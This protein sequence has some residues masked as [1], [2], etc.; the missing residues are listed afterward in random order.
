MSSMVIFIK[1]LN[2]LRRVN[3]HGDKL[4]RISNIKNN[5][6]ELKKTITCIKNTLERITSELSDREE[7]INKLK[8][9]LVEI[10][11]DEQKKS[12]NKERLRHL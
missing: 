12:L 9:R 10:T 3:E 2:E 11:Q 6:A 1:M 8:D 5:Q 4:N 7:W